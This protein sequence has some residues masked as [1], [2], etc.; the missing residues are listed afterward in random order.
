M[1]NRRIEAEQQYSELQIKM[2]DYGKKLYS[3]EETLIWFDEY[4]KNISH[5][6]NTLLTMSAGDARDYAI[7]MQGDLAL[8]PELAA[9]IKTANEYSIK[10]RGVEE[11]TD[12][13]WKTKNE[14]IEKNPYCF[15]PIK[16]NEG[17]VIGG[18]LGTKKEYDDL[19][20]QRE[21]LRK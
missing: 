10:R 5:T 18:R 2:A 4:K 11:R 8:D 9:R 12:W 6:Y 13:D 19:K 15:I 14:W 3:D 21:K 20:A 17:E 1:E 16:N 7:R